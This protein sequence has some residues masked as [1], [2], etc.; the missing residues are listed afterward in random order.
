MSK[1]LTVRAKHEGLFNGH[2]GIGAT[3]TLDD[4]DQFA[5]AWMEAVGWTPKAKAKASATP[6]T[7]DSIAALAGFAQAQ[8]IFRDIR[9]SLASIPGLPAD[10]NLAEAVDWAG[11]E[12]AR[13][14]ALV[15]AEP[16]SK[17]E[18]KK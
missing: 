6:S 11:T 13:L 18:N 9:A 5:A 15:P 7:D 16:P 10:L 4:E 12:I 1:L 17:A 14:R 3:F 2:R 8:A